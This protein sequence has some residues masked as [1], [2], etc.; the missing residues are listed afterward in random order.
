MARR[1]RGGRRK[2]PY[3]FCRQR[4]CDEHAYAQAAALDSFVLNTIEERLTGRDYDGVATGRGDAAQWRAATFVPR[5]G[6]DDDDVAEAEEA[7]AEAKAD[8]DG[9]LGD[10]SLRSILGPDKYK[11]GR[12]QLRRGRQ[13]VRGR[14]GRGPPG[15]VRQL[16]AGRAPLA[17]RVGLGGAKLVGRAD[18]PLR[19]RVE[20]PRAVEPARRGR[21]AIAVSLA[22][23][24]AFRLATVPSET[25]TDS[26][27]GRWATKHANRSARRAA[28]TE[29][30]LSPRR[31]TARRP[32]HLDTLLTSR[33]WPCSARR[34]RSPA[35]HAGGRGFESRRSRIGPSA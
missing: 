1:P 15:F 10:T 6:G 7:L 33:A 35:C 22:W 13:Q 11:R 3:C 34:A 24:A 25:V 5:P 14:P 9:L 31:R 28:V 21:A 8:L 27:L 19:R 4:G 17:P 29:A 12:G 26:D 23:C 30:W 18:S 32:A 20:G 2:N 16:R